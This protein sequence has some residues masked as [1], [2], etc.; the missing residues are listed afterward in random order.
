MAKATGVKEKLVLKQLEEETK[1]D[2]SNSRENTTVYKLCGKC[3]H[4]IGKGLH[5]HVCNNTNL[6]KNISN[7]LP[8]KLQ[9][10]VA[11]EVIKQ[12]IEDSGNKNINLCIGGKAIKIDIHKAGDI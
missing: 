9:E 1:A 11:S 5:G 12:K 3:L 2:Q 8:N 10:R 4:P 7:L 6:L